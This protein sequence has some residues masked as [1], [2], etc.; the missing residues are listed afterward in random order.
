MF[1]EGTVL[2]AMYGATIGRVGTLG[3]PA[4]TNQAC[5]AIFGGETLDQRY[6]YWWL[7]ANTGLLLSMALGAGQPNISQELIRSLRV[8]APSVAKQ[9]KIAQEIERT[10]A[11]VELLKQ[12]ANQLLE[13]LA[14]RRRTLI[15]SAVT[16]ATKVTERSD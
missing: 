13:V 8:L 3:V 7:R 9:R 4:A 11:K 6:L 15:T 5:C 12:R 16:G 10:T 1:P 14:E 2:V